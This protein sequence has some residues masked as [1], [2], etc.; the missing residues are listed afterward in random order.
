L[1]NGGRLDPG[2][3]NARD[4]GHPIIIE[5]LRGCAACVGRDVK[6]SDAKAFTRVREGF[7]LSPI[8]VCR[9]PSAKA[10]TRVREGFCVRKVEEVSFSPRIRADLSAANLL[11]RDLGLTVTALSTFPEPGI[12]EL[13]VGGLRMFRRH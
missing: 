8:I 3:P 6:G 9:V 1:I 4:L 10:F 7:C 5:V 12:L 2:S 11:G 13:R